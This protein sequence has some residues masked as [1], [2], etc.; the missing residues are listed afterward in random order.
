MLAY[1]LQLEQYNQ[2]KA[3]AEQQIA[4]MQA[5]LAALGKIDLSPGQRTAFD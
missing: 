1:E 2:Q 5:Q 3:F 4:L